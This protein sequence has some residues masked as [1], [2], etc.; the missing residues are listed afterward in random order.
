[1]AR[2]AALV[3]QSPVPRSALL[4]VC[5]LGTHPQ[6]FDRAVEWVL[7]AAGG[8]DLVVQHGA[9]PARF[10]SPGVRWHQFLDYEEFAALIEEA[11]VVVC[12]AGVG[13]LM[14]AIGLGAVPIAIPRLRAEGEHVD[15]HQLQIAAELG[16]SGHVVPCTEREALAS[17]LEQ[18]RGAGRRFQATGGELRRAAILAAGGTPRSSQAPPA[19]TGADR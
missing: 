18:A 13:T 10:G 15:D 6:P 9:T 11:D 16:R 1:V 7:D 12:H 19:P 8:E 14:T 5:A 17:A 4:I 2:G 3:P